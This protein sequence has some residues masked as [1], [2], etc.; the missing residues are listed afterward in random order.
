MVRYLFLTLCSLFSF[1]GEIMVNQ[2]LIRNFTADQQRFFTGPLAIRSTAHARFR[3]KN[4]YDVALFPERIVRV[5]GKVRPE[6]VA[7]LEKSKL[8]MEMYDGKLQYSFVTSSGELKSEVVS[9]EV[10]SDENLAE[11]A[12]PLRPLSLNAL[13]PH[14]AG[15]LES[16]SQKGHNGFH[17]VAEH[18]SLLEQ[19]FADLYASLPKGGAAYQEF[20]LYCYFCCV[21]L[22]NY[23]LDD[24]YPDPAKAKKYR[25]LAKAIE[26]KCV[27]GAFHP[28]V[29]GET[30]AWSVAYILKAITDGLANLVD[31]VKH[32]T[33]IRAWLGFVNLYRILFL[34][35]RLSVKQGLMLANQLKWLE[36]LA[37]AL[38][39]SI[40]LNAL[41]SMI[42]SPAGIFNALSVGIFEIRAFIM[43][44][45]A[46]KHVF[47]LDTEKEASRTKSERAG[48]EFFIRLLDFYNDLAWATVNTLCNYGF[49]ADPVAS[50][51]TAGF[52][53][54]DAV[55]LMVRLGLTYQDYALKNAQYAKEREIVMAM[56]DGLMKSRCGKVLGGK[57]EQLNID[58]EA[59]KAE[60]LFAA[61]GALLLV[62]GFSTTLLLTGPAAGVICFV[63]C[64]VAV[65]MY[66]S[67]GK[68]GDYTRA[69]QLDASRVA[70]KDTHA[71]ADAAYSVF[72]WS[73]AKNA[74]MPFVMVTAFAVYWPAALVL[75][76]TY[77]AYESSG[78]APEKRVV[79]E[80]APAEG[81]RTEN[82]ER[83]EDI[84]LMIAP[85]A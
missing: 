75:A 62:A 85:A 4:R 55:A 51:L 17:F 58:W 76:L 61:G 10:V 25:N 7:T 68:F 74:I 82:D 44:C 5:D 45:E 29:V 60:L 23:Y 2:E 35:G 67:S 18:L 80:L 36:S 79:P 39:R 11:L 63:S 13:Q 81:A 72:A 28:G 66:I 71:A 9:P 84:R 47:W 12:D 37:G 40:D 53:V 31:T 30:D 65:A 22:E 16:A 14:L 48:R 50:W 69:S 54:L 6:D 26:H 15:I 3:A 59:K 42:N 1:A 21:T 32:T 8:Y 57:I 43:L 56:P 52:L 46:L 64:T 41:V 34:F 73:M 83:D 33:A 20:W 19:Q 27:N 38:N 78:K 49:I 77:I 70:T 24:A